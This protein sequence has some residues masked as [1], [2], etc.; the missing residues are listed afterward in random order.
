MFFFT[1][2]KYFFFSLKDLDIFMKFDSKSGEV[3]AIPEPGTIPYSCPY[4][5]P[6]EP[7]H[8]LESVPW[9]FDLYNVGWE[10]LFYCFDEF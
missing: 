3:P 5:E 4:V 1:H 7:I 6:L 8:T 10:K 2:L 9:I